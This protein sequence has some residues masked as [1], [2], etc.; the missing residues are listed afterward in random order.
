MDHA[1]P[2]LS[3]QRRA[4][5]VDMHGDMFLGGRHQ[6]SPAAT[7]LRLQ[8][9]L[10]PASAHLQ[11]QAAAACATAIA[12]FLQENLP[13]EAAVLAR[14]RRTRRRVRTA[15]LAVGARLLG[16]RPVGGA[17]LMYAD[18]S[19]NASRAPSIVS[20]GME[21]ATSAIRGGRPLDVQCSLA[22]DGISSFRL[23]VGSSAML[24][25]A[26]CTAAA[27]ETPL[28]SGVMEGVMEAMDQHA[29]SNPDVRFAWAIVLGPGCARVCLLEHGAIHVSAV[30]YT[31]HPAGCRL[32][33][34]A[35]AHAG[36]K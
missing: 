33:G 4:F 18:N 8:Q 19:W 21:V 25:V 17:A 31:T 14:L 6:E 7:E 1:A 12:E 11:A 23:G 24:G 13:R 28:E 27:V 29:R 30:Q 35:V 3:D 26:A 9:R 34:A 20:A 36:R 5:R 32:L 22:V 2:G 16:G 15:S 10:M